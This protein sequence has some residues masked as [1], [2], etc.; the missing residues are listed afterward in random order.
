MVLKCVWLLELEQTHTHPTFKMI[1]AYEIA[2]KLRL[3]L[4]LIKKILSNYFAS[5]F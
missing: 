1:L 5:S 2:V 4:E 3:C